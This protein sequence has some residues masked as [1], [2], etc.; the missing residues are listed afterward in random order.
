MSHRVCPHCGGELGAEEGRF[1]PHCGGMLGEAAPR[2]VRPRAAFPAD[3]QRRCPHCGEALYR[4]ERVCWRCGRAVEDYAAAVE[5]PPAQTVEPEPAGPVPQPAA[6]PPARGPRPAADAVS[7][8]VAAS[9][10]WSFALGLLSVFTCGVLG[11]L[12]IPA[13][14]LGIVAGRRGGGAVAV[15]GVVFAVV[16]LLML[17]VWLVAFL[18]MVSGLLE[19]GVVATAFAAC[20]R[21]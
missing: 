7:P 9:A 6:A 16:G 11:L 5:E 15:A 18:L 1:C 10:W 13:L 3:G 4:G 8:D 20:L 21:S 17:A 12:G 2:D 14:W 19:L